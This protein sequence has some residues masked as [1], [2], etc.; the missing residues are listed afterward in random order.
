MTSSDSVAVSPSVADGVGT[1]TDIEDDVD[2]CLLCDSDASEEERRGERGTM[3][4][5]AASGLR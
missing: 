3:G 2:A 1:S 5:R 4:E